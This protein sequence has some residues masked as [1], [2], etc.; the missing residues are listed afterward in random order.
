MAFPVTLTV[1]GDPLTVCILIDVVVEVG[2]FPITVVFAIL[3]VKVVSPVV[4]AVV[5]SV[6]CGGTSKVDPAM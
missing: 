4:V 5:V 1:T 2:P 6:F 3:W